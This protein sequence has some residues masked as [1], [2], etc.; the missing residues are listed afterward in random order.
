VQLPE[1]D[2]VSDASSALCTAPGGDAGAEM[3]DEGSTTSGQNSITIDL[4]ALDGVYN[5]LHDCTADHLKA[6]IERIERLNGERKTLAGD[7]KE[8]YAEAKGNG[9]DVKALRKLIWLRSQDRDALAEFN[10]VVATYARAIDP[11]LP[12]L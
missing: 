11:Q 2:N 6:T 4:E 1:N 8:V 12:L 7:L 3:L 5:H 9:F 10:S